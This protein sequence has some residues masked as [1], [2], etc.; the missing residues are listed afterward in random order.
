MSSTSHIKYAIVIAFA[1]FLA[2]TGFFLGSSK[3]AENAAAQT[4]ISVQNAYPENSAPLAETVASVSST[5]ES[6]VNGVVI[7]L[8]TVGGA[9]AGTLLGLGAAYAV[10]LGTTPRSRNETRQNYR[11]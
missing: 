4:E 3:S 2:V 11:R 8:F 1:A 7:L 10:D 9:L 5:V 6:A